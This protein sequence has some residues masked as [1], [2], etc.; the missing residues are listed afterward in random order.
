MTHSDIEVL[1][2][3]SKSLGILYQQR[4]PLVGVLCL[5]RITDPK[6]SGAAV[7]SLRILEK[8]C[9][10]QNF[11]YITMVSTMWDKLE[12]I[13]GGYENGVSREESLME[14]EDFWGHLVKYG[15]DVKKSW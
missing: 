10:R 13:E 3:I 7:R 2:E 8:M 14:K 11:R 1:R 12:R 9:G 4:F 15:S 6:V 5:H